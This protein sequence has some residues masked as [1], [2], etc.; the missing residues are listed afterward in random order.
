M[1]YKPYKWANYEDL[2]K[3][4]GM[5]VSGIGSLEYCPYPEELRVDEGL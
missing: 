3:D 4:I 1:E 5:E 2:L